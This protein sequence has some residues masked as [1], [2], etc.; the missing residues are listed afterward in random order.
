MCGGQ[1][2]VSCFFLQRERERE[3]EEEKKETVRAFWTT[4]KK[5]RRPAARRVSLFPLSFSFEGKKGSGVEEEEEE[6][7]S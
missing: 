1:R 7:I 5:R 3:E 6:I 4:A 2:D